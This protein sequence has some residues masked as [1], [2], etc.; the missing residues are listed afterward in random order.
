MLIYL[1]K[2]KS[3][4]PQ[5]LMENGWR[6]GDSTMKFMWIKMMIDVDRNGDLR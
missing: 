5:L 1:V 4:F 6:N 3:D 2:K